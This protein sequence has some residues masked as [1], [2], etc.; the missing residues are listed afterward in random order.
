[1]QLSE[2]IRGVELS[3]RTGDQDPGIRK[4]TFDSRQVE[5][6]DLFVAIAG[7]QADGHKY[8]DRAIQSGAAAVVCQDPGQ[9]SLS[10]V[11]LLQ[12]SNSRQ[13][14]AQMA[15]AYYGHPS[16][17]LALVGVT[18]TNGKTTIATLLHQMHVVMGFRQQAWEYFHYHAGQRLTTFNF[19][20]IIGR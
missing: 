4:I 1:M 6:G 20:I 15:A 10:A 17:E 3:S 18:G 19:Y 8:M 14:L 12:V 5:A 2:I 16:R 11:P 9:T 7:Q 13:A